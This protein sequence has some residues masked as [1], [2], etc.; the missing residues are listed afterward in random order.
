[1]RTVAAGLVVMVTLA[2]CSTAVPGEAPQRGTPSSSAPS[3]ASP[4]AEP[5]PSARSLAEPGLDWGPV[6]EDLDAARAAVAAMTPEQ[7]AGQVVVARYPGTDPATAAD[8]VRRHHLAGVILMGD[9]VADPLQ[10]RATAAAVQ[11][12]AGAD[13]RGWPAVVAVDQEGGSVARVRSPA[14]EFPTFMTYGA[15][16]DDD[17][18][19]SAAEASGTELR[20]MGF[21]VVFAPVADVTTGPGDPTIGSRSASDDPRRVSSAVTAALAGYRDAGIVA[22]AKH[23][24]GHG[25]VPADSH[26]TLP[27]QRASAEELAARDLVPF[28]AAARAGAPA[29]MMSHIA[30]QSWE[31]GVPASLSPSAYAALRDTT[32]FEGVTVTDAL[33]M[34][35]VSGTAGTGQA[36]V[37]AL[38]AGADLLLMPADTRAAVDAV[39]AAIRSGSSEPGA[40]LSRAR[41]EEAA[42]RVIALLRMQS[43]AAPAP[44]DAVGTSSRQSYASSLAGLTVVAGPCGGRLVGDSVQVVGGTSEDHARFTEAAGAAGLRT[45]SGDVVRL[46]GGP[47]S[48]GAGD[49]VVALDAPYGLGRS[50]ARTAKLALY[51]RTPEAFRALVD[52]LLGRATATGSL[53]VAVEGVPAAAGCP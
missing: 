49:V 15:A 16:G 41:V 13:E 35:A 1:M 36:A 21:T 24:P 31:P 46:L 38:A 5:A 52:V 39:A 10:V 2:A 11:D 22:V 18:A 40:R 14:T 26:E 47:T 34:G 53:P 20:S 23:Y 19:R 32:G 6:P 25:S 48:A 7:L 30:V 17:V 29:V 12:A 28:A 51:G 37:R 33:N 27:V 42:A 8:L 3:I 43:R 44:A 4:P 9:N 50:S 45:G